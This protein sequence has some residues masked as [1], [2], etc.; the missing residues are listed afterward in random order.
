[1]KT[2]VMEAEFAI[3]DQSALS[4]YECL[5]PKLREHRKFCIKKDDKFSIDDFK[6]QY[7]VRQ[8]EF[9]TAQL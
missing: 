8:L 9:D 7:K 5:M 1:M 2:P 3:D 6:A 4:F